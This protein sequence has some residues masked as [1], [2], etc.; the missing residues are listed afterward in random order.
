MTYTDIFTLDLV[1][2]R[3]GRSRDFAGTDRDE[4]IVSIYNQRDQL[5]LED[6][7]DNTKDATYAYDHNGGQTLKSSATGDTVYHWDLRGRLVGLD[8]NADGQPDVSYAYNSDGVRISQSA[9]GG[10]TFYLIDPY[11]PTGY[12]KAVEDRLDTNADGTPDTPARTYLLGHQ[13]IAQADTSGMYYL[14]L[15]GHGSTRALTDSAGQPI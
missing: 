15:D 11:N 7:S 4:V 3:I 13:I 9:D 14:L 5:I 8:T 6:S 2:N 10:T 1:G 12:A